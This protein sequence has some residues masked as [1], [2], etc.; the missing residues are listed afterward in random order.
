MRRIGDD[1]SGVLSYD[2]RAPPSPTLGMRI[3]QGLADQLHGALVTK[4]DQG[5]KVT[6]NFPTYR[7]VRQRKRGN[8]GHVIGGLARVR[9][10]CSAIGLA[11][12]GHRVIC[13]AVWLKA[14]ALDSPAQLDWT[15]V[16][17]RSSLRLRAGRV[18][19]ADDRRDRFPALQ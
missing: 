2:N 17:G 19:Q 9:E 5:R 13:R 16:N 3:L 11:A 14:G 10:V 18:E 4:L 6:V 15:T 8:Q 7:Q 1:E 12:A